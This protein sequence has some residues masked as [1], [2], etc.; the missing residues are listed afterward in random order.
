[1]AATGLKLGHQ[2][3]GNPKHGSTGSQ[4]KVRMLVAIAGHARGQHDEA[5]A[6]NPRVVRSRFG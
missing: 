1:V 6:E 4:L 3:E 5:I 2:P